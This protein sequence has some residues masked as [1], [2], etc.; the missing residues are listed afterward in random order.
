MA[1]LRQKGAA[2][3]GTQPPQTLWERAGARTGKGA[4]A[5]F[6]RLDAQNTQNAR[7]TA[8]AALALERLAAQIRAGA[9]GAEIAAAVAAARAALAAE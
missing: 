8:Q 3:G 5:L 1:R 2:S 4:E 7:D 9:W 6:D